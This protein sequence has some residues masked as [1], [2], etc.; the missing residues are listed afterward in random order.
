MVVR[1][2]LKPID[3][4]AKQTFRLASRAMQFG[5]ERE[6]V[7]LNMHLF[8]LIF[9]RPKGSLNFNGCGTMQYC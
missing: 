9:S 2:G 4:C 5:T 6:T 1:A 3:D 7:A 8:F